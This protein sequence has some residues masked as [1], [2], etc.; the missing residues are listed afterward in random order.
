MHSDRCR[1]RK[2][3]GCTATSHFSMSIRNLK[4]LQLKLRLKPLIPEEYDLGCVGTWK[5]R[6]DEAIFH[7]LRSSHEIS[8]YHFSLYSL[9]KRWWDRKTFLNGE[10]YLEMTITLFNY[11]TKKCLDPKRENYQPELWFKSGK[12]QRDDHGTL[13]TNTWFD[14]KLSRGVQAEKGEEKERG[15][16]Y[17]HITKMVAF[18]SPAQLWFILLGLM[19]TV[20]TVHGY[21]SQLDSLFDSLFEKCPKNVFKFFFFL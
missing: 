10:C 11:S 14:S 4:T 12:G 17:S 21:L 13:V 20:Y 8:P 18:S 3:V 6:K 19:S 9:A 1:L 5:S 2:Q 7:L 16:H 15:Q